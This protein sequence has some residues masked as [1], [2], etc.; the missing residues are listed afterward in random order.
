MSRN[1]GRRL[2]SVILLAGPLAAATPRAPIPKD[3]RSGVENPCPPLVAPPNQFQIG[4]YAIPVDYK[5][6][7]AKKDEF[8]GPRY[9]EANAEFD[10]WLRSEYDISAED[11]ADPA[12]AKPLRKFDSAK[13]AAKREEI[14]KAKYGEADRALDAW[15]RRHYG[16]GL[17][18]MNQAVQAYYD[19][20][21]RALEAYQTRFKAGEFK[22]EAPAQAAVVCWAGQQA[23]GYEWKDEGTDD[24]MVW[25]SGRRYDLTQGDCPPGWADKKGQD[26]E[27]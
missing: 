17:E 16:I 4:E 1:R 19:E 12:R 22:K 5:L 11:L 13:A 9:A 7:L 26:R 25:Y 6:I 15:L 21:G 20:A 14:L 10:R 23:C 8:Y 27:R 18:E 3:M 2:F 24:D